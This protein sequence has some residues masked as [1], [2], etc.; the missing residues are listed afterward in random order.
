MMDATASFD[1]DNRRKMSTSS[2]GDEP[3]EKS[4]DDI[5]NETGTVKGDGTNDEPMESVSDDKQEESKEKESSSGKDKTQSSR[6][7]KRLRSQQIT[8]GKIAERQSNR[9]SFEYCF[10]AATMSCTKAEF[11]QQVREAKKHESSSNGHGSWSNP[12]LNSRGNQLDTNVLLEAKERLSSASLGAFVEQFGTQS[13]EPIDLL[14]KYL[15]HVAM[16]VHD[17]FVTDPRGPLELTASVLTG[18]LIDCWY[19]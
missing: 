12:A 4:M 1:G 16:N 7:S 10:L 3:E 14:L 19:D 5:V 9:K 13:C 6:T 18:R 17:V 11:K 15:G 8:S 2:H